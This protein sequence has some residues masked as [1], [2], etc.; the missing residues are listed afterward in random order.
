MQRKHRLAIMF[1]IVMLLSPGCNLATQL[2]NSRNTPTSYTPQPLPNS[3]NTPSA[4]DTP[5]PTPIGL[6]NPVSHYKVT[7]QEGEQNVTYSGIICNL[8]KPFTLKANTNWWEMNFELTP[9]N[10]QTG[11][12]TITGAH[13]EAGPYNGEGTYIIGPINEG[14]SRLTL[15][16]TTLIHDTSIGS[17][18][19][20]PGEYHPTLIPLD[21]RECDGQ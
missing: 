6:P 20:N 19:V 2:P 7:G 17:F 18:D 14:M 8:E 3:Q 15:K 1:S 12:F 16:F 5:T 10:S 11:T 13:Y 9:T 4:Q 21:T